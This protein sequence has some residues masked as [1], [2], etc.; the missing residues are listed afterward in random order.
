M[1][2][3]FLKK[4]FIVSSLLLS[5]AL[6]FSSLSAMK[7][8]FPK[9][10]ETQQCTSLLMK[11]NNQTIQHYEEIIE[12]KEDTHSE[13]RH[14]VLKGTNEEIGEAI[15]RIAQ[16]WLDIK[17]HFFTSD[18]IAQVNQEFWKEKYP[19]LF[20]RMKGIQKAYAHQ[21][22]RKIVPVLTYDT[23]PK[24]C[25]AVYYPAQTKNNHTFLAHNFDWH[26]GTYEAMQQTPMISGTQFDEKSRAQQTLENHEMCSRNFIIELYPT[27]GGYSSIGVGAMDFLNGL[28]SGMNSQGLCFAVL[29]DESEYGT[30]N[31]NSLDESCGFISITLTHLIL[32]TCASVEEAK[33]ILLI[34]QMLSFF[35][36]VHF[37][38][39][40]IKG[41]SVICEKNDC[42]SW[43]FTDV[44]NQPQVLTNHKYFKNTYPNPDNENYSYPYFKEINTFL[45][46]FD[47]EFNN[48][49][50][51]IQNTTYLTTI[52]DTLDALIN[53]Q[54]G[55]PKNIDNILTSFKN[56]TEC[57]P[58]D[59]PIKNLY[60]A[61][62]KLEPC[63]LDFLY[64]CLSSNATTRQNNTYM[65]YKRL[66]DF[67]EKNNTTP[68]TIEQIETA[69]SSVEVK[70]YDMLRT[71]WRNVYDATD[72]TLKI[73]FYLKDTDSDENHGMVFSEPFT[74]KLD[75][76]LYGLKK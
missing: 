48:Q 36:G 52:D 5:T 22:T 47:P 67:F 28:F 1:L 20:N 40:D 61:L 66:A 69:M 76:A 27:D 24:A 60:A 65:R 19:I 43:H 70:Y 6:G 18:Y 10:P 64:K 71:L 62:I 68:I 55:S 74:F 58:D 59:L 31:V 21:S 49:P 13:V 23:F 15:G 37:L 33:K 32:D 8:Q 54:N 72:K 14:I 3:F 57:N 50:L 4:R 38:I 30:Q 34:N 35:T 41:N 39:S 7:K 75:P 73:S 46:H 45:R 26:L 29:A 51:D 63:Y 42:N 17:P 11:H 53:N 9:A 25:S 16:G 56:Y 12:K 44:K 2:M